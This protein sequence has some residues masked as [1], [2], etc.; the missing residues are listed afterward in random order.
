MNEKER[1]YLPEEE[2]AR[3]TARLR[4]R[5][6]QV[7]PMKLGRSRRGTFAAFWKPLW[8]FLILLLI[9]WAVGRRW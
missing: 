4:E 5:F 3:R 1:Y 6:E 2:K 8:F 7:H 9:A